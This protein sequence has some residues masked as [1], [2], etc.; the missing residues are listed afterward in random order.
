MG[1]VLRDVNKHITSPILNKVN[2]KQKGLRRKMAGIID[3]K[4]D[5]PK[6]SGNVF[7]NH[8]DD[9]AKIDKDS[10]SLESLRHWDVTM[11]PAKKNKR[12]GYMI[13]SVK[14]MMN[15]GTVFNKKRR[16]TIEWY[17]KITPA[18]AVKNI[19]Q[20]RRVFQK[21]YKRA[22]TVDVE[23]QNLL[24]PLGDD[25]FILFRIFKAAKRGG[26]LDWGDDDSQSTVSRQ[27]PN[28]TL[29]KRTLTTYNVKDYGDGQEQSDVASEWKERHRTRISGMEINKAEN[30]T[31]EISLGFGNDAMVRELCFNNPHEVETF[32]RT[33]DKMRELMLERGSRLAAEHRVK[34]DRNASLLRTKERLDRHDGD[35]ASKKSN[36][37][38]DKFGFGRVKEEPLLESVNLLV[39]IV[40]AADLPI[41]GKLEKHLA[42]ARNKSSRALSQ[43]FLLIVLAVCSTPIILYIVQTSLQ[44]TRMYAYKMDDCDGIKQELYRSH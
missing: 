2:D 44:A 35:Q 11:P 13:P 1:D 21:L 36:S 19:E 3:V 43:N 39:E 42:C 16:I 12:L 41:A 8:S 28:G 32:V 31:V 4:D 37:L 25:D 40:S 20:D 34:P 33:F 18:Q 23:D 38:F 9:S 27:L 29:E 15:K 10:F 26:I 30:R 22:S 24:S 14:S 7:E 17:K 5:E 6:K